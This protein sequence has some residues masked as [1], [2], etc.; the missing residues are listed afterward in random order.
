VSRCQ[1]ADVA[2]NKRPPTAMSYD[3]KKSNATGQAKTKDEKPKRTQI[4]PGNDLRALRY[5][6]A[7]S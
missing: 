2:C 6:F 4:I 3:R 5:Y 1:I 7:T